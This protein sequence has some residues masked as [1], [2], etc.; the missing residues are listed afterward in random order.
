MIPLVISLAIRPAVC[1]MTLLHQSGDVFCEA[2]NRS[3]KH[4]PVRPFSVGLEALAIVPT[5]YDG[6]ISSDSCF[7]LRRARKG[8]CAP[9]QELL[10]REC[11][12]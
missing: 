6:T 8:K 7:I 4:V 12:T 5:Y 10:Q 1:L 2:A 9:M 11:E 3:R